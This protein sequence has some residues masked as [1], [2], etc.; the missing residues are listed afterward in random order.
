MVR[1]LVFG[2]QI[3]LKIWV[4]FLLL[5]SSHT[6]AGLDLSNPPKAIKKFDR[7]HKR[8]S[9]RVCRPGTEEKF[10]KLY[11]EYLS[12]GFY[13]PVNKK[14]KIDVKTIKENL[15]LVKDKIRFIQ[16]NIHYLK[17]NFNKDKSN[18][19][20]NRI[21]IDLKDIARAKTEYKLKQTAKNKKAS[22]DA[23]GTLGR[24][25]IELLDSA[26][27]L[28][29]FMFPVDYFELRSQ[30]DNPENR[31]KLPLK[32]KIYFIRK[33]VEDGALEKGVGRSDKFFRALVS[34]SYLRLKNQGV[35]I[36]DGLYYDFKDLIKGFKKQFKYGKN[37][38]I[39]RQQEWLERTAKILDFYKDI[40]R[41]YKKN[42]KK[43]DDYLSK[44]KLALAKLRDYVHK[45]QAETYYYW[46]KRPE[47]YRALFAIETILM[48]EVGRLDVDGSLERKEVTRVVAKRTAMEEYTI[49]ANSS[50][51]YKKIK[52][53]IKDKYK[54]YPWLNVLFKEGEFSFTY[55]FLH[56]SVRTFCPEMT[57]AGKSLR[58][59][60]VN[61]GIETL[62][63]FKDTESIRYFSRASMLGRISM[64]KIWER[65]IPI[66]E[67]PGLTIKNGKYL[68][69]RIRRREF[70]W[71][72]D[73]R[74]EDDSFWAIE[75]DNKRYIFEEG[76]DQFYKYRNPYYFTYFREKTLN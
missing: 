70:Y 25:Y 62:K 32:N 36:D 5:Y 73:F 12:F 4:S 56:A 55:Y 48:N 15:S 65:F 34:T 47:T 22:L 2:N 28:L 29:S 27:F 57:F 42:P 76:T 51:L 72:Y 71:L 44:R 64:H 53:K 23:I 50:L 37:K 67:R 61:I 9:Q 16:S 6:F 17:N 60:N 33:I 74:F 59:E 20:L 19:I 39:A 54:Q 38:L 11:Q 1:A 69:D 7:Y 46:M 41:N 21:K 45:K 63:N 30:Y 31:K 13:I 40:V 18:E 24:H 52:R 75:I 26:P 58:K 3:L 8:F 10:N 66:S 35:V 68:L 14:G 43:M 49:P